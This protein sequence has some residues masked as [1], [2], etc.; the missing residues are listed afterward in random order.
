MIY[1]PYNL[2]S[3]TTREEIDAKVDQILDVKR[4][5]IVGLR[6]GHLKHHEH[7]KKAEEELITQQV[8]IDD[9]TM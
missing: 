5:K 1:N 3:D 6:L 4:K 7:V 2:T 8:N 9:H